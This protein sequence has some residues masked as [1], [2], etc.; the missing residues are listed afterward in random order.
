M[1]QELSDIVHTHTNKMLSS[2]L[3]DGNNSYIYKLSIFHLKS[4]FFVKITKD[5][6]VKNEIKIRRN[7]LFLK[8]RMESGKPQWILFSSL[9]RCDDSGKGG[10]GGRH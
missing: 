10:G 5:C 8:R 4:I 6:G 2:E 9:F 1:F 3:C 7:K